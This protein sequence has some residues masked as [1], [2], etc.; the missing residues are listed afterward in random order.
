VTF[1]PNETFRRLIVKFKYPAGQELDFYDLQP[2]DAD[3]AEFRRQAWDGYNRTDY[4]HFTNFKNLDYIKFPDRYVR[5]PIFEH[6][7]THGYETGAYLALPL[8]W[9]TILPRHSTISGYGTWYQT[10]RLGFDH[11]KDAEILGVEA[12][13]GT[14]K[15]GQLIPIY[16]EFDTPVWVSRDSDTDNLQYLNL[17]NG[18]RAYLPAVFGVYF[19]QEFMAVAR[20][21]MMLEDLIVEKS[22]GGGHP[23]AFARYYDNT[24]PPPEYFELL[25][26]VHADAEWGKP[27]DN[28]PSI[29]IEPQRADTLVSIETDKPSYKVGDEIRVIL[30]LDTENTNPGWLVDGYP[31]PEGRCGMTTGTCCPGW[32]SG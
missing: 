17:A 32:K 30:R 12:K 13:S 1:P 3:R 10:L 31:G 20:K 2:N 18:D 6:Y 5:G 25:E 7:L 11:Y 8:S 28:N 26:R 27:F 24:D 15:T 14:Y 29:V 23:E 22:T 9:A 4:L 19:Y 16:V 21:G